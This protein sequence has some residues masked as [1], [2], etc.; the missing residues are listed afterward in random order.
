MTNAVPLAQQIVHVALG[1]IHRFRGYGLHHDVPHRALELLAEELALRSA[2]R[3]EDGVVL[4][5]AIQR[6]PFGRQDTDDDEGA[7]LDASF[8]KS[9][10]VFIKE[11]LWL[12]EKLSVEKITT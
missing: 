1:L 10:Q 5:A 2:N 8:E 11:F 3:H 7:L 12:C 6:L 9:V 4:V